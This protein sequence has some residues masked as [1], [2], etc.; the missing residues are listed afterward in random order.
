MSNTY[1]WIIE[2]MDC[3]PTYES[4]TDVVFT[5]HW[6]CNALSDQT[7]VVNGQSIP[8]SATIYATQGLTY[9]SGSS[10]TPYSQLTQDQVLEWIWSSGVSKTDTQTTLDN[11]INSQ[12]N[13]TV[14]SPALPWTA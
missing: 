4:Q 3:Y 9:V 13:P 7:Y 5:V 8:C 6:R 11:M 12:I 1:T 2:Q 10:Y 14:V